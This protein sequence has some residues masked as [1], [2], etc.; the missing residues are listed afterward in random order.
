MKIPDKRAKIP[1]NKGGKTNPPTIETN[2][3]KI[4]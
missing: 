2:P 3:T 4:R 1:I